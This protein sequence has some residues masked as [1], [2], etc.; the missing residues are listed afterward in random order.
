MEALYE[1]IASTCPVAYSGV[2]GGL[3]LRAMATAITTHCLIMDN[4]EWPKDSTEEIINKG[5]SYDF[6]IVGAGTAGSLVASYLSNAN[7]SWSVLLIEAGD[8]T[9]VD[10]E[11]PA[12]LF[13][14]QNSKSD[15]FYKTD[16]DGKSCL[17]FRNKSCIWSKGKCM[18]GSSSINAMLYI[19]GHPSDYDG[20]QSLGNPEWGYDDLKIYFERQE[21]MFNITDPNFEGYNYDWYRV[22]DKAWNELGFENYKYNGHEARM[23][24]RIVRILTNNGQR[25]NTA[26][27]FLQ[28]AK[29]VTVMKN[30]Q[31]EK[32]ILDPISNKVVGLAIKK[33]DDT[34]IIINVNK[35]VILSA[36]SIGTPVILMQSGIGPKLHLNDVGIAC[37]HDL[38]VGKNLQDHTMFPLFLKT[39]VGTVLDPQI[40]NLLLL[41][42]V[43]TKTGPFSNIGITDYMGFIDTNN[44]D[45]APNV[46][47]HHTYFPKKDT[48]VIRT[49]LE[50]VGYENEIIRAVEVVNSKHDLLGIYPTLLQPQ[51]IGEI[52]VRNDKSPV[53]KSNYFDNDN[54]LE[55]LLKSIDFV[56]KL[57]KTKAFRELGIEIVQIE[58]PDC[59]NFK[60]DSHDYWE[61]YIKHMTTTIYHPV[62]TAKMGPKGDKTAVVDGK[63]LVHGVE[64]LRVVDASVMP[65]IPKANT[66]AATLVIAQKGADIVVKQHLKTSKDEL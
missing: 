2:T 43:L 66:M 21:Q 8:D 37:V 57:E 6:V 34:T 39:N 19:R 33:S 22:L 32:V 44:A 54:D 62:G 14:N 10:S 15:W 56:K 13:L 28:M 9:G 30:T 20:W 47:F 35:E 18:G 26:R 25:V 40:F 45:D 63:L 31:V 11:I 64:N 50:G 46:Q 59:N 5:Q 1:A 4:N 60:F 61:C 65:V 27:F 3:F 36:G 55:T 17:G 53:I 48:L 51:S 16:P 58:I 23:G 24:T 52:L 7:P 29:N 12:F 41:Q 42:Y 49:Y 38:P